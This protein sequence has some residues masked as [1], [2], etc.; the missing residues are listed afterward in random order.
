MSHELADSP[1]KS[2]LKILS[3]LQLNRLDIEKMWSCYEGGQE[4][5][6]VMVRDLACSGLEAAVK[7][8]DLAKEEGQLKDEQAFSDIVKEYEK[9]EFLKKAVMRQKPMNLPAEVPVRINVD[10]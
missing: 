5:V 2:T 7:L 9:L 1:Q 6:L 10:E 4:Q 3:F 8:R